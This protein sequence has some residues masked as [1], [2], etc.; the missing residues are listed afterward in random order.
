M[1]LVM[2]FWFLPRPIWNPDLS[3]FQQ[4]PDWILFSRYMAWKFLIH[5][6]IDLALFTTF[7]LG[8]VTFCLCTEYSGWQSR[9]L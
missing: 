8:S 5:A 4:S 1:F 2:I 9:N 7:H 3:M 6:S